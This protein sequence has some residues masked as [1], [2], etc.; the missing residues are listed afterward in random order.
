MF[1]GLFLSYYFF[2]IRNYL[3]Y[4]WYD[5]SNGSEADGMYTA[6][7]ICML[8][9]GRYRWTQHPGATLSAI[10][11]SVYR[12]L[13][14]FSKPHGKF[15]HL[16]D[17]ASMDEVFAMLDTGART[18]RVVALC[19]SF[20]FSVLLYALIY[21]WTEDSFFSVLS[22][23]YVIATPAVLQHS[24]QIRPDFLGEIILFF[25]IFLCFLKFGNGSKLINTAPNRFFVGIGILLGFSIF[26]KAQITPA[27]AMFAA[28]LCFY[29][30]KLGKKSADTVR[31]QAIKSCYRIA[32]VNI[33][34]MPWWALAKPSF[35]TPEYIRSYGISYG[36]A[37]PSFIPLVG[38]LLLG[39]LGVSWLFAFFDKHHRFEKFL[40]RSWL[41]L[42]AV[43]FMVFGMIL[44]SYLVL[45]P[46]SGSI[47]CYIK[48]TQH[49]IYTVVT[50]VRYGVSMMENPGISY[51]EALG[52]IFKI[53]TAQSS[54]LTV[55]LMYIVA[56]TAAACL[57]R[58]CQKSSHNR[59]QYILCLVFFATGHI[60]D[61]LSSVRAKDFYVQ[62]AVY[63]VCFFGAGL[64][65]W[66]S[67]EF[68][69]QKLVIIMLL[70]LHAILAGYAFSKEPRGNGISSN[71]PKVMY[72]DARHN[73]TPFFSDFVENSIARHQIAK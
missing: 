69:K 37:P 72:H 3:A 41:V 18:G 36:P 32:W 11:G 12:V 31:F 50:T 8:N 63:S 1:L 66:L 13:G 19:L 62:Y 33:I 73:T 28:T 14:L 38:A 20:L 60:M 68:K 59:K 52:K 30:S 55:N 7:T 54:F 24:I 17:V 22:T 2:G 26:S 39:L 5:R 15:F 49:L 40:S 16:D 48:N 51:L 64:A 56:F 44:S 45:L 25:A 71:D 47:P 6:Q 27:I 61:L 57:I 29:L 46:V 70:A 21:H 34:L 4:P 10:N 35:L 58:I 9:G 65:L 67:L 42:P 53:H 23:F 43:Y